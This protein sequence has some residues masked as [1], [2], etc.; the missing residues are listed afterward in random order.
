MEKKIYTVY[1][2]VPLHGLQIDEIFFV[3]EYEDM[4]AIRDGAE[5]GGYIFVGFHHN[6]LQTGK[7]VKETISKLI[8]GYP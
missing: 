8:G 3:E 7:G 5:E 2:R 6:K 1:V 4:E